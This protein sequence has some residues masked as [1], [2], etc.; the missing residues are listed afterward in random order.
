MGATIITKTDRLAEGLDWQGG[1]CLPGVC[2]L[3]D[4]ARCHAS[5][6]A[7][8]LLLLLLLLLPLLLP[9]L[10]IELEQQSNRA[11]GCL[12]LRCP[13]GGLLDLQQVLGHSLLNPPQTS[14]Q[15]LPHLQQ[16]AP[17]LWVVHAALL[18]LGRLLLEGCS[19]GGLETLWWRCR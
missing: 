5:C 6:L 19:G 12:W 7:L 3:Q 18:L 14:G 16:L 11:S 4:V 13:P 8:L 1:L 15:I 9:L 17:Q 10:P 2:R